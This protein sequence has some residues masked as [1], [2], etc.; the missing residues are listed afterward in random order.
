MSSHEYARPVHASAVF[1]DVSSLTALRVSSSELPPSPI[2]H[3]RAPLVLRERSVNVGDSSSSATATA[4]AAAA[5][6]AP[7]SPKMMM[8]MLNAESRQC[9]TDSDWLTFQSQKSSGFGSSPDGTT[10]KASRHQI[11]PEPPQTKTL[12]LHASAVDNSGGVVEAHAEP[13]TPAPTTVAAAAAIAA[14]DAAAAAKAADAK[15]DAELAAAAMAVREKRVG[16]GWGER[17]KPARAVVTFL[18]EPKLP[19]FMRW[20]DRQNF[21][22]VCVCVLCV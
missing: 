8:M 16:K 7:R 22:C 6:A 2:H 15:A 3:Q 12:L 14:A 4:A 19:I 17:G 9:S 11:S 1:D 5:A 21:H 10:P 18:G 13:P 20:G